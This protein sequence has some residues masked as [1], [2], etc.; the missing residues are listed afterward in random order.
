[1]SIRVVLD[2]NVLISAL[3][4]N[5]Q[6]ASSRIY[7]ACKNEQL[8]LVT[9]EAILSEVEDVSQ[10]PH[11]TRKYPQLTPE[12]LEKYLVEIARISA[13]TPGLVQLQ[14]VIKDPK[15]DPI[16]VCAVEGLAAYIVTGDPHLLDLNE[17]EEIKIVTP[18]IFADE[19][20]GG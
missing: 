1:M 14:V 12:A 8:T 3:I 19:V 2:T 15:D 4:G 13:L 11:L 17:F 5:K 7:A 16:I 18:R 10:R 6:G 9:S 20:L